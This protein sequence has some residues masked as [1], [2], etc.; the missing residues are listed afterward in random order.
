MADLLGKR[1]Q[2]KPLCSLEKTHED[3]RGMLSTS[4]EEK[5]RG[6]GG[7]KGRQAL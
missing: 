3:R 1:G 5:E 6:G 2:S 4:G 7:P